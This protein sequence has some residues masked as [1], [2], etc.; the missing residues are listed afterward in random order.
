VISFENLKIGF[1]KLLFIWDLIFVI[2]NSCQKMAE[3]YLSVPNQGG[4]FYENFLFL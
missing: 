1:W 3:N 2:S 4:T